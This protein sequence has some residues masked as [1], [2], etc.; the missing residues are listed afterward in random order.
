MR[1]LVSSEIVETQAKHSL[2]EVGLLYVIEDGGLFD[3][4]SCITILWNLVNLFINIEHLQAHF[5]NI[6]SFMFT[7]KGLCGCEL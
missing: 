5:T 3:T 2:G 1:I 7:H 6:K 4:F